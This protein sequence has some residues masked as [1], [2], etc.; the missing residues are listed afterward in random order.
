MAYD[1]EKNREY[2]RKRYADQRADFYARLG[3]VCA[4][5]GTDENLQIDHVDRKKKSFNIGRLWPAK[6][7]PKAYKELKKCQLLCEPHH[8]EKT[9]REQREDRSGTFTHGTVYAWMKVKCGCDECMAAKRTWHDA[10][11]AKRRT[12]AARGPY[13]RS[14][15]M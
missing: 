14:V 10:R 5:C 1:P 9:A 15:P 12:G 3:G 7:L 2:L 4:V 6:D 11:N 13:R 8:V